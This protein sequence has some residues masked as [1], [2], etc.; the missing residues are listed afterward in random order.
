MNKTRF[1]KLAGIITESTDKFP[2]LEARSMTVYIV[3]GPDSNPYG[4]FTSEQKA[5]DHM[6][7][8]KLDNPKLNGKWWIEQ[9][10]LDSTFDSEQ[11]RLLLRKV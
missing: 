4:V 11:R 1:I 3:M 2:I 8:E 5:K 10:T 9:S 7:F 6:K